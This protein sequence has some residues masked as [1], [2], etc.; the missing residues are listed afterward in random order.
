MREYMA[1][2]DAIIR[3]QSEMLQTQAASL[4]NLE[5]QVGQLTSA[6]NNRPQGTLQSDT[7]NQRHEEKEHCKA[8]TLR[9]GRELEL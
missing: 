9:S 6:L 2:N 1:K 8:I 5:N 4:R 7:E 3:N